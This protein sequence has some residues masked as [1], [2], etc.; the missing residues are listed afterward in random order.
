MTLGS[1]LDLLDRA[2]S[3]IESDPGYQRDRADRARATR[4][5]LGLE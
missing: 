5:R 1:V 2:R 4:R 3:D